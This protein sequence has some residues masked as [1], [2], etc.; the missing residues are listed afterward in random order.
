[1]FLGFVN[2]PMEW[3]LPFIYFLLEKF[4]FVDYSMR[5]PAFEGSA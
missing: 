5:Q 3:E 2:T 1:M 4:I